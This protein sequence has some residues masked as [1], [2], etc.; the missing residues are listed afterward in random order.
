MDPMAKGVMLTSLNQD[1]KNYRIVPIRCKSFGKVLIILG[2]ST[3][4]EGGIPLI[5]NQDVHFCLGDFVWPEVSKKPCEVCKEVC[6]LLIT[7]ANLM[8]LTAAPS[9]KGQLSFLQYFPT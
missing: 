6:G 5:T 1:R 9:C 2:N 4:I 7:C 8:M 3:I